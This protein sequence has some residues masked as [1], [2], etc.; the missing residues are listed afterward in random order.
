MRLIVFHGSERL[1]GKRERRRARQDLRR[2][3]E[4]QPIYRTGKFWTD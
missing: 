1:R 4:P 3:R 2:G